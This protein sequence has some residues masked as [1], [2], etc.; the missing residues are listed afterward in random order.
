MSNDFCSWPFMA[1][2]IEIKLWKLFTYFS[3]VSFPSVAA[4]FSLFLFGKVMTAS[5]KLFKLFDQKLRYDRPTKM[6]LPMPNENNV[7][8]PWTNCVCHGGDGV[9][10]GLFA[11]SFECC[12]ALIVS[13]KFRSFRVCCRLPFVARLS[14]NSHALENSSHS[15]CYRRP[16]GCWSCWLLGLRIVMPWTWMSAIKLKVTL[17]LFPPIYFSF[18]VCMYVCEDVGMNV[19]V[20]PIIII[21]NIVCSQ[22]IWTTE[23]LLSDCTNRRR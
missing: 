14:H 11:N 1:I 16:S 19:C 2:W 17:P 3:H 21:S 8:R 10:V 23:C 6:M 15:R 22:V 12:N 9:K 18:Y 20:C 13:K 5:K 4:R 7:G